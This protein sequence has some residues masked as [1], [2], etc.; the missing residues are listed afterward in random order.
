MADQL[1]LLSLI[2]YDRPG[3]STVYYI[4]TDQLELLS[5]LHYDRPGR[6]T[7]LYYER[8]ARSTV[9]IKSWQIS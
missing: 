5:L 8:P 4:L 9:L 7:Q 3:R 2:Y 1:E 6:S